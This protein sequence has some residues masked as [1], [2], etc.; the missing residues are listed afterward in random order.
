MLALLHTAHVH[1]DTF[2]RLARELD[3]TIPIRHDVRTTFLEDVLVAGTIT[4]AVRSAIDEAVLSLARDGAR[5]IVC[6]CSTIGGVVEAAAVPDGVHVLRIDRPMAERA[7]ASNRR[8]LVFAALRSTFE[9]TVALLREVASKT[10]R[11][12]E[13]VEVFCERAWPCFERGDRAGYLREIAVSIE[14]R[15]RVTDLVLLAQASMAEAEVLVAHLGIPILS[16]PRLG[17][18]VAMSMH[19]ARNA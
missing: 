18:Q 11:S 15:A 8:I 13:L 7:V 5:V 6:T 12:M 3:D 16:S 14:S 2:E 19:R 1:V 9:P 17:L 10:G 4:D